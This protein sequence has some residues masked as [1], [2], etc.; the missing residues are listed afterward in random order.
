MVGYALGGRTI[1]DIVLKGWWAYPALWAMPVYLFTYLP[2]LVRSFV[3]HSHPE[4]DDV[5]D[6]H[7]LV[8]FL[9]NPVERMFFSPMNMNYHIAHHLWPSIP[10]YNLP[11]ADA[12]LR[13]KPEALR[14]GLNWRKTYFGYLW[15][16]YVALPL[17]ECRNSRHRQGSQA[18]AGPG[19]ATAAG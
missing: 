9:S 6:D 3:E 17:T 13:S 2:N 1:V 5:A 4:H 8:T 11:I 19:N 12:E 7:R 18:S 16:Y 10:Y 15:Q 14:E